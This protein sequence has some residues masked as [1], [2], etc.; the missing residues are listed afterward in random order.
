M[1][2]NSVKIGRC[3]VT[4]CNTGW[5]INVSSVKT[6]TTSTEY[7]ETTADKVLARICASAGRLVK[8]DDDSYVVAALTNALTFYVLYKN[9]SL[10]YPAQNVDELLQWV[11]T[12]YAAKQEGETDNAPADIKPEEKHFKVLG[13][14]VWVNAQGLVRTLLSKGSAVSSWT[15]WTSKSD[16]LAHI[17]LNHHPQLVLRHKDLIVWPI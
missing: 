12:L 13:V 6:P 10:A 9:E 3:V 5:R 4:K 16:A 17:L 7:F 15:S 2:N 1:T 14:D 11:L 8:I